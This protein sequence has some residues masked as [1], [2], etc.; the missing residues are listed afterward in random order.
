MT[1]LNM[2]LGLDISF[3]HGT[4]NTCNTYAFFY[5]EATRSLRAGTTYSHRPCAHSRHSTDT[6][7]LAE[8]VPLWTS[9]E[10]LGY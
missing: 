5:T 3:D 9:Q 1:A 6:G 8:S 10:L 2:Y 4:C 7:F